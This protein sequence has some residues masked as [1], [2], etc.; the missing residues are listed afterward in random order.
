MKHL[1]LTGLLMASP[2]ALTGVY[3]QENTGAAPAAIPAVSRPA[4]DASQRID[5]LTKKL[6][7][8]PE[9]AQQMSAIMEKKH[10]DKKNLMEKIKTNRQAFRQE[11]E[12]PE[13]NVEQLKQLQAEYKT[14]EAERTDRQLETT[15]EIKKILNPVQFGKYTVLKKHKEGYMEH[16]KHKGP[17]GQQYRHHHKHDGK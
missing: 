7:L 17:M 2:L 9:Q 1:I 10:A 13:S 16:K 12:K 4:Q 15:L 6:G 14:L 8:T 3:A 11:I 5:K